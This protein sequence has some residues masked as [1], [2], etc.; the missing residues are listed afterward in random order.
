[1]TARS[2]ITVAE[3]P[4]RAGDAAPA[5]APGRFAGLRRARGVPFWACS[6]LLHGAVMAVLAH[7]VWRY[8]KAE[9]PDVVLA[10][11][12]KAAPAPAPPVFLSAP[13]RNSVRMPP[14]PVEPPVKAPVR[15]V[16]PIKDVVPVVPRGTDV[17]AISADLAALAAIAALPPA[18]KAAPA[19]PEEPS[20]PAAPAAI[21]APA[22]TG[23][24]AGSAATIAVG[25]E[26]GARGGATAAAPAPGGAARAVV[27]GT[28]AGSGTG[29]SGG[30]S[31][32]VYGV[33]EIDERPVRTR[34]IAPEFP[35]SARLRGLVGWVRLVFVVT[36]GGSVED[37]AVAEL[38]GT[39]DFAAAAREA[40][41]RWEFRPGRLNGR[42]VAVRC[43]V[44]ITFRP[45]EA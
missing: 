9:A 10:L 35:S 38:H 2:Q 28:A 3:S 29:P 21:S 22:G 13:K 26:S 6:L 36:A 17:A 44:K 23:E 16:R 34:Y 33:G 32:Q 5:E 41:T 8:E 42:A 25:G 40:A 11:A 31:A 30:G 15:R 45:P 20:G 39:D 4:Q 43:S 19:E 27:G 14:L 37:I 1:M 7:V 18:P 12:V 24:P